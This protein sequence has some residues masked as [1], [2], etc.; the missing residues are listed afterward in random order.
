MNKINK[1]IITGHRGFIGTNF[2]NCLPSS[3]EVYGIDA[4]LKGSNNFDT[5][6]TKKIKKEYIYNLNDD[7]LYEELLN[8]FKT[9]DDIVVVH[10]AAY[11]H[12]DDSISKP[13]KIVN[14]NI[15]ST[16]RLATFCAQHNIPFVNISTDEVYGTLDNNSKGFR[17]ID[18]L[19]PRNPYS[20]SKACNEMLI[21]SLRN[22]YPQWKVIQ[23]RCVNNFGP[24]QDPT[25]LIP[26][27]VLNIINNKKIPV[28]GNGNQRRT[29]IP[30]SV[31]NKVVLFLIENI[32]G[33][34]NY[35]NMNHT[36]NIGSYNE[37]SNIELIKKI[38]NIL[39]VDINKVIEY[40]DD[41]R[42]NAHD[43]RYYLRFENIEQMCDN[44]YNYSFDEEL[45]KTINFY[46]TNKEIIENK[47]NK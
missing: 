23:T 2:L 12:V 37:L 19:N 13:L 1:L 36:Y 44:Y 38:C 20:A 42:G 35:I 14:E 25:K 39:K 9:W 34:T 17:T 30:V 29:W 16:Y 22:Q 28:Y 18:D 7:K 45:K 41:P 3:Y 10:F 24:Y 11:S 46:V 33:N 40:I 4:L 32:F 6:G 47:W 27:C 26:T 15:S 43:N 5:E 8:D 21:N 31:H